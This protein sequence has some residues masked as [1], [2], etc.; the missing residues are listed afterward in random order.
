M[1][2]Q[3]NK[4]LCQKGYELFM[5]GAIPELLSFYRDDAVWTQPESE[6]T[7]YG[8]V[9]RTKAGIA[10]FFQKLNDT[11]ELISMKPEQFI[12]EDD[13]VVVTGQ[14]TWRA[15]ATGIQ[16]DSPWVHLFT[17]RDGKVATAQMW[18]DTAASEH[19]LRPAGIPRA[20]SP[21]PEARH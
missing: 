7:P 5:R 1:S 9:H 3:E 15:R 8:G 19:A 18:A 6:H 17:V 10:K 16:F 12:A 21:Q 2:T 4:Q 11:L 20:A 14:A 13:K